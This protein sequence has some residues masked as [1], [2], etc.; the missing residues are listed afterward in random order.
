M[1]IAPPD[2]ASPELRGYGQAASDGSLVDQTDGLGWFGNGGNG[3]IIAT[4]DDL[5]SAMQAIVGGAYLRPD[6]TTAM[7]TPSTGSYGLGIGSYQ[8]PC[9]TVYGHQGG[10]NGTASIAVASTDGRDGVV[11]A[12]NLRGSGDPDLVTLAQ[13]LVCGGG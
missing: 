6:L 11:I 12:F 7:L 10:V 1:T 2:T 3:G 9:G 13:D 4:P 5:L 8:F